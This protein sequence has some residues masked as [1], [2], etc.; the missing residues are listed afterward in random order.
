[1]KDLKLSK[2]DRVTGFDQ[3]L[4]NPRVSAMITFNRTLIGE[5]GEFMGIKESVV[6]GEDLNYGRIHQEGEKSESIIK[7]EAAAELKIAE[8]LIEL[9]EVIEQEKGVNN[10]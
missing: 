5:A 4:A 7:A 9:Y 2:K 8:A 10:G 6:I 3:K 1:M